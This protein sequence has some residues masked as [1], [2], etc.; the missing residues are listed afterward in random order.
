MKPTTIATGKVVMIATIALMSLTLIS[1]D[2]RKQ[3]RQ[4][5]TTQNTSDTIPGNKNEKR[6]RQVRNLDEAIDNLNE[7]DMDIELG[8]AMKQVQQALKELDIAKLQQEA[9]A[10]IAKLDMEKVKKEI[11]AAMK[12]IDVQKIAAQVQAELAKVDMEKVK[13]EME[14]AMKEI[15][16]QKIAAQAQAEVSKIDMEKMKNELT[17]IK[18]LKLDEQLKIAQEELKKVEPELRKNMEEV[19]VKIE[20]V[21]ADLRLYKEL[22]DGLDSDGLINKNEP[23]TIRHKNGKLQINGKDASAETYRKYKKILDKKKEFVLEKTS[24][25]FRIN[26][27]ELN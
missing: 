11:E 26:D 24:D 6:D 4:L 16:V 18:E 25:D 14:A 15:D 20:K 27:D 13:K 22:V 1:W 8:N 21:K 17:S 5:S 10:S 7:V 12:E 9:A 2:F 3:P 23:Y 19:K